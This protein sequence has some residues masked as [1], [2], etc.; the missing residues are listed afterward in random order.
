MS[1]WKSDSTTSSSHTAL[2]G[3]ALRRDPRIGETFKVRYSGTE[4]QKT[5][6]G[7]ATIVDLCSHGFGLTGARELKQ[8]WSSCSFSNSPRLNALSAS[9]KF[10]YCGQRANAAA[11]SS[12]LRK[13]G[14]W[15]GWMPS[16]TVTSPRRLS[17]HERIRV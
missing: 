17:R 13:S 4:G 12:H 1:W 11:C 8:T 2:A 10:G 3:A 9:R 14:R 6:M 16:L 7:D 5:V 15:I